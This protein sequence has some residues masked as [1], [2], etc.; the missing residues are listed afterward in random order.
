MKT[1]LFQF[2]LLTSFFQITCYVYSSSWKS[3]YQSKFELES[4][5][6]VINIYDSIKV[7]EAMAPL[8]LNRWGTPEVNTNT[9]ETR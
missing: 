8:K 7:K 3:L 4:R 1:F 5:L 6:H 9:M 2:W